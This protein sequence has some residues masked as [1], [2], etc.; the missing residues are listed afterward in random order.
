MFMIANRGR[1]EGFELQ[2]ADIKRPRIKSAPDLE[3]FHICSNTLAK[4]S[5]I[6]YWHAERYLARAYKVGRLVPAVHHLTAH[7]GQVPA[8]RLLQ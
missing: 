2:F 3:H 5:L 4:E 8:L 1:H 6:T 7:S